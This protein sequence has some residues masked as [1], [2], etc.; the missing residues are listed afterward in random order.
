M[1]LPISPTG[2]NEPH[3]GGPRPSATLWPLEAPVVPPERTSV[4]KPCPGTPQTRFDEGWL[5]R[6]PPTSHL[7]YSLTVRALW[8]QLPHIPGGK[9][10]H[11]L[12]RTGRHQC[13]AI[14]GVYYRHP[15]AERHRC[16][17]VK[18]CMQE[19]RIRNADDLVQCQCL[20]EELQTSLELLKS[21][22]GLLQEIDVAS[23]FYNVKD[24][25]FG[26]VDYRRSVQ[27]LK[28]DKDKWVRRSE[29]EIAARSWPTLVINEAQF[30]G[31]GRFGRIGRL[32]SAA[33]PCPA[34]STSMV[35][36]SHS[37]V[38]RKAGSSFP[39]RTKPE[40][41]SRGG[42]SGCSSR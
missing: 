33:S 21:R 31:N 10:W 32:W 6:S 2:S 41:R 9:R 15:T 8:G 11:P 29:D 28:Q 3:R 42:R 22:F 25:D 23:T 30:Q 19:P 35:L 18:P 37:T 24:D 16:R 17:P 13:D 34:S 36:P 20:H 27:I 1:V 38:R 26:T 39:T 7:L 4:G 5:R 12:T 40:W 14:A